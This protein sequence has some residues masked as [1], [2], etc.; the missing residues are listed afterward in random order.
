MPLQNAQDE[1]DET[2]GADGHS[3][4][5]RPS[6]AEKLTREL[7]EA[8]VA[9]DTPVRLE[10][11]VADAFSYLGFEARHIGGGGK[12]DVLATVEDSDGKPVRVILDAK[13]SRSGIV[14]EGAVSFDALSEHKEKHHADFVALVGTSFDG[15]RVRPRAE[16]NGVALITV[17]ELSRAL[18][19]YEITPRSASTFLG[20]VDPRP[21]ARKNLEGGWSLA[22]RRI[23]LLSQVV[24]VLA[25]EAREADEVTHGALSAEQIYLI[26]RDEID[27][28][29][30]TKDIEEVLQLLEHPLIAS[31]TRTTRGVGRSLT[32]RL[33]D[34]PG[35]V[36]AKVG[37]LGRSIASVDTE[38]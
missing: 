13:A 7:E 26:V 15:G 2:T 14:N 30:S 16:Q 1:D 4:S 10:K 18:R 33:I 36:A 20:L 27:P 28:R 17:D 24:A 37:A 25:Q 35:L 21:G 23:M 11:A 22:E 6:V 9:G 3:T 32:Y 5:S 38:S 8:A 34:A 29:P 19:R 12:A 31:V